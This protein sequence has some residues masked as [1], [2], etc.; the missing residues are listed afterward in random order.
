M[1]ATDIQLAERLTHRRANFARVMALLLI[2]TQASDLSRG[3]AANLPEH[4]HLAAWVVW[5]AVLL[6]FLAFG[7]GWARNHNVRGL[8]NDETTI[9][10][11]RRAFSL[12]FWIAMLSCG[13]IWTLSLFE[14]VGGQEA[15]RLVVTLSIAAALLR[16][17]T[18]EKKSLKNG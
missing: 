12:G 1:T 15:V 6:I 17:A 10:H 13:L 4:I 14:T 8:M 11:R 5:C 2:T 16:F 7:G 9:E 3:H 18:L